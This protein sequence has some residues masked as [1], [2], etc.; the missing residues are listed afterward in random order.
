MA[1]L[2]SEV[3]YGRILGSFTAVS[4]DF[5]DTVAPDA[6]PLSG[7]VTF[8]PSTSNISYIN[9]EGETAS[10]YLAP[11][12]AVISQGRI[13]GK[14]GKDGVVLL[15]SNSNNVSAS[16]LWTARISLDPINPGDEA[17][18][19]HSFLIEVRRGEIA[20]L[21]DVIKENSRVHNIALFHDAI[22]EAAAK[23][24]E[25]VESGEFR[26]NQGPP[27]PPG[28]GVAGPRGMAGKNGADGAPGVGGNMIPDGDL[29]APGFLSYG[30]YQESYDA[31]SGDKSVS[32]TNAT[33]RKIAVEPEKSY[34]GSVYV[35]ADY[36]VTFKVSLR[37]FGDQ[38]D[39][40]R[41][42]DYSYE[43]PSGFWKKVTFLL[44][45]EVGDQ[46]VELV[47]SS[48]GRVVLVDNFWLSDSSA[49]RGLQTEL[50]ATQERIEA[51]LDKLDMDIDQVDSER[52]KLTE[53]LN[54]LSVILEDAE[55]DLGNVNNQLDDLR[56]A[57]ANAAV[58]DNYYRDQNLSKPSGFTEDPSVTHSEGGGFGGGGSITVA[59]GESVR[60]AYDTLTIDSDSRTKVAR[61]T[62]YKISARIQP[63]GD[64][65]AGGGYLA[66][67]PIT[68]AGSILP[69]DRLDPIFIMAPETP[70]GTWSEISQVVDIPDGTVEVMVGVFLDASYEGS[71]VFSDIG[72]RKAIDG[73]IIAPGAVGSG[74]IFPDSVGTPHLIALAITAD[75]IGANAVV[76][77]KIDALAVNTR[78]LAAEAVNAS[79]LAAESVIAGKVAADSISAREIIAR[80]I[81]AEKIEADSITANEIKAR[82]ITAA[83]IATATITAEEIAGRTITAENI[84]TGTITANE[85]NA[86]N[87]T[88]NSAIIDGLWVNGLNTKTISTA[89]LSV[90]PG[91]SFPDPF[92][93]DKAK[94]NNSDAQVIA[95]G[96]NPLNSFLRI[97][98]TSSQVG[99]Y[100][101]GADSGLVSLTPGTTYHIQLDVRISSG[102]SSLVAMYLRGR[103]VNG[104][105]KTISSSF[106]PTSSNGVWAT[107]SSSIT[108]PTTHQFMHTVGL[109]TRAPYYAGESVDFRNVRLVPKVSS[110]LIEDGA[111]TTQTMAAN[112]IDGDRIRAGSL[113]ADKITGGSFEGKTFTGGT[114]E[115]GLV[116]GG[117]VS[118][119]MYAS[120]TGGVHLSTNYGLRA[121]NRSGTQTVSIDPK[122][123]DLRMGAGVYL[124]GSDRNGLVLN[125]PSKIGTASIYFTRGES[126]GANDAA[127]WRIGYSTGKE[128]LMLRGANGEGISV[129][130]EIASN[131]MGGNLD[132]GGLLNVFGQVSMFDWFRYHNPPGSGVSSSNVYLNPNN[133]LMARMTSSRRYKENIRDWGADPEAVLALQPRT[134]QASNPL[135]GD[136]PEA[137][138]VVFVAEEVHDLG[139]TELVQYDEEGK[140]DALH[141]ATFSV[142]QQAV[143][144]KHE[145]EIA[146]LRSR[147]KELEGALS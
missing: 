85:L 67:R 16:V 60:G 82:T 146:D 111:V 145:E 140:P 116:V 80:S 8:V 84:E 73:T 1:D 130:S 11:V 10:L 81:T 70:G 30:D 97:T 79:K 45:S 91:N 41:V 63:E 119:S 72:V 36:D 58:G 21:I 76:A 83:E 15:A 14:D 110:T 40:D 93:Q 90:E 133:G 71:A 120:T 139:L 68:V 126:M 26:G 147:I 32:L 141:Y 50:V 103:D 115:G 62:Q 94:W 106:T 23:F 101:G 42:I 20:S 4:E 98:T 95:D 143:L 113:T 100:Y 104:N 13:V 128:P 114:F 112:S 65:P 64:L 5:G 48:D 49:V 138:F 87:I 78:E 12:N 34:V 9:S 86:E 135:E 22:A 107:Y 131:Y 25:R 122:N 144:R 88:A 66:L 127:I 38:G 52:V 3:E 77:G 2:L 117:V 24:W 17:P 123:G 108:I 31:V 124:T 29:E 43:I 136:D 56:D 27:G 46:S 53:S 28:V 69:S 134:W 92:F 129:P 6:I 57:L 37:V 33:S 51:A 54:D 75:K 105:I 59:P 89:R 18:E 118:T 132:V 109:Y 96:P 55:I 39:I 61:G 137:W 35:K 7:R 74:Q 142:A 99:S 44:D 19:T 125:P 102:G 47:V 121:W